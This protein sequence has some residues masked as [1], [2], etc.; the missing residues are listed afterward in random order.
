M[1]KNSTKVLAII[2][3]RLSSSRLPGK[4]LKPILGKPML[5]HQIERI[6]HCRNINKI[7]VG[8]SIGNDD[9]GIAELCKRIGIFCFR[10]SLDNVLDRFYKAAE[11]FKPEHV[12]RLTGDCPLTDPDLIDELIDFYFSEKCDY[13]NNCNPPTLP[14]GLDAEI[15]S[16]YTLKIAWEN[17]KLS[18]ELEHVTSYIRNHPEKF[19]LSSWQNSENL[20]HLR[21][22]VDEPMDFDLVKKIYEYLYP[23]KATFRTKDI[24]KLYESYSDLEKMNI[25]IERNEGLI[26]SVEK[27]QLSLCLKQ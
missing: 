14:D 24:L 10:G 27:D 22:T 25:G 26:K 1:A 5:E 15:F 21:W 9:D 23:I 4:V 18:S 17:S 20:S 12:V 19:T 16:F 6:Q 2:Q 3:A 13:A 8:T 11:I 7:I